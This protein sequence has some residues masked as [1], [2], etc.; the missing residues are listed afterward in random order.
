MTWFQFLLCNVNFLSGCTIPRYT[1]ESLHTS[2]DVVVVTIP[3]GFMRVKSIF[4]SPIKAFVLFAQRHSHTK[5]WMR[6]DTIV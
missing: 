1:C 6:V 2:L 4:P 3:D 5:A